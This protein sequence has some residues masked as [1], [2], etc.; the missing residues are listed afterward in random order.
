MKKVAIYG[1]G[2]SASAL[3]DELGDSVCVQCFF[4]TEPRKSSFSGKPVFGV[5]I[6]EDNIEHLYVASMFYPEIFELLQK[7]GFP[8]QKVSAVIAHRDDPRFGTIRIDALDVISKLDEYIKFRSEILKV[9]KFVTD[10]RPL[11]F[12]NR[13]DHLLFAFSHAPR[14]GLLLEFGVYRGESLLHLARNAD[15]EIWGFDSFEGFGDGSIWAS[16]ESGV[17]K[18]LSLPDEL[19]NYPYLVKGFFHDTLPQWL[20]D[21]NEEKISFVHYDAGH[22]EAA[23]FVLKTIKPQLADGCVILFDELVPS[24]TELRCNEFDALVDEYQS[25]FKVISR[26]SQSVAVVVR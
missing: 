16:V 12:S 17:R 19:L 20:S 1:T 7:K 2:D 6:L 9:E 25:A 22:Y 14:P 15:S 24:P 5:E 18:D 10:S 11:V 23:R 26:S 13:L 3:L 21:R 4:E 8:M